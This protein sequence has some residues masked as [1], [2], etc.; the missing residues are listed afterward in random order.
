MHCEK[1]GDKMSVMTWFQCNEHCLYSIWVWREENTVVTIWSNIWQSNICN[2]VT[3]QESPSESRQG[4]FESGKKYTYIIYTFY[5]PYC[6]L[7]SETL[8]RI[9]VKCFMLHFEIKIKMTWTSAICQCSIRTR[10]IHLTCSVQDNCC[11]DHIFAADPK[12]DL[13]LSTAK[14]AAKKIV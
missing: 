13:E 9:F 2:I 3:L 5:K 12:L 7:W 6:E 4:Q 10:Q 11:N 1:G 14:N 8:L